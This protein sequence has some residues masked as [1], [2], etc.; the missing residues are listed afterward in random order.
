MHVPGQL[1]ASSHFPRI[2][3]DPRSGDMLFEPIQ[4]RYEPLNL[5]LGIFKFLRAFASI[6]CD[7]CQPDKYLVMLDDRIDTPEG[8]LE[9]RKPISGLFCNIE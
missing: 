1:F 6:V 9:G 2:S 4:L 7:S 5:F 8:G 3:V